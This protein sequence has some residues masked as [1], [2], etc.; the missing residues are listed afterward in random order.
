MNIQSQYRKKGKI[1][2][3]KIESENI[4]E[5]IAEEI[6]NGILTSFNAFRQD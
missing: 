5:T 4:E 1:P 6:W 2:V 3:Q